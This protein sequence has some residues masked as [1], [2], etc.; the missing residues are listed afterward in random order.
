M[1]PGVVHL[2]S[3]LI[4]SPFEVCCILVMM[5]V[6]FCESNRRNVRINL[7]CDY[8]LISDASFLGPLSNEFFRCLVLAGSEHEQVSYEVEAYYSKRTNYS[9]CQ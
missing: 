3:D 8:E 9:R 6:R 5:S 7:G 2:V 1:I 4:L